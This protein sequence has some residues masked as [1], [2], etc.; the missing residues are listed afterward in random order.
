MKAIQISFLP[1]D[2]EE[3]HKQVEKELG[4]VD[5]ED[6]EDFQATVRYEVNARLTEY[7][8]NNPKPK[9]ED[10]DICKKLRYKSR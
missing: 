8:K 3:L 6:W 7:Y 10:I 1:P 4:R 2:P 5:G 9:Y